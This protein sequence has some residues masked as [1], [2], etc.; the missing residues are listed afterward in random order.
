MPDFG[1]DGLL[2]LSEP[3]KR[4]LQAGKVLLLSSLKTGQSS[5]TIIQAAVLFQVRPEKVWEIISTPE[6]QAEYLD[7]I[8]SINLLEKRPEYSRLEFVVK[9]LG[10]KIRYTV[11][12]YFRPEELCLWWELDHRVKNDLKE[13]FGFWRFYPA[14]G[15]NTVAR[16]GS[17]VV[18]SFPVPG[19]IK[20]WLFKN[21][22]EDSLIK[23]KNYVEK[24]GRAG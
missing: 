19:F 12:H 13:L 3:Q 14:A 15:G 4:D 2:G 9:I 6:L 21:K 24:G 20:D 23:V 8:D 7:D 10:K 17:L 5:Q 18:P 1:P 11:V 22:V 16:Y